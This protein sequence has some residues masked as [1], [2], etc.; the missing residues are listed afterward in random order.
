MGTMSSLAAPG[1]VIMT[2]S[3]ATGA[4]CRLIRTGEHRAPVLSLFLKHLIL[5]PVRM[6]GSFYC[7]FIEHMLLYM[8]TCILTV[9]AKFYDMCNPE[10]LCHCLFYLLF[11]C[12]LSEMMNER[13][14]IQ[15][16]WSPVSPAICRFQHSS[17]AARHRLAEKLVLSRH[18]SGTLWLNFTMLACLTCRIFSKSGVVFLMN[19]FVNV[20]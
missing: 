16:K 8:Y 18:S 13:C 1:A 4:A 15:S 17:G 2:V 6:L 10:I 9:L 12:T 19:A 11:T 14:P 3:C 20:L 5:Y 7:D